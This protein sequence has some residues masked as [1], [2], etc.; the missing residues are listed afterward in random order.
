MLYVRAARSPRDVCH[1]TLGM[2]VS[3]QKSFRKWFARPPPVIFTT[4]AN[5]RTRF[6]F[7]V[8]CREYD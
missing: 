1:L 3:E 7:P 4:G 5:V 8:A 6:A 2:P